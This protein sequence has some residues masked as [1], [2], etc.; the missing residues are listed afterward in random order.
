MTSEVK[1]LRSHEVEK[2][3][4]KRGATAIASI[5]IGA[6]FSAAG[7]AVS[8]AN[9]ARAPTTVLVL[10]EAASGTWRQDV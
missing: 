4:N 2:T 5:V 9:G 6:V 3:R 1:R 10:M 7:T 8:A